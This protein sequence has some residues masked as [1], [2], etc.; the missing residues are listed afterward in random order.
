MI[1]LFKAKKT[2]EPPTIC[3]GCG[4]VLGRTYGLV[5]EVLIDSY[6]EAHTYKRYYCGKC[7]PPYTL[8]IAMNGKKRPVRL[9]YNYEYDRGGHYFEPVKP[10][11]KK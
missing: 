11:S 7:K 9:Y 2:V 4:A 5:S 3:F 1:S 6:T 10:G 8:L